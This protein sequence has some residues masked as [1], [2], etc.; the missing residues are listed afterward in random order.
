MV[1][2]IPTNDKR[3]IDAL[4]RIAASLAVLALDVCERKQRE[5]AALRSQLAYL[6]QQLQTADK[7][8]ELSDTR[9][10]KL[11]SDA[12]EE[13]RAFNQRN[14]DALNAADAALRAFR[15]AHPEFATVA[16]QVEA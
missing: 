7:R 16:V 4:E 3:I 6:Q 14:E 8:F 12:S 11:G 15:A 13:D 5:E 10:I 1:A 9:L 2:R